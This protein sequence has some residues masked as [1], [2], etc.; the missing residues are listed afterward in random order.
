MGA[1]LL[2]QML[3][4]HSVPVTVHSV[5]SGTVGAENLQSGQVSWGFNEDRITRVEQHLA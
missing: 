2:L 5:N 3:R 4:K 1:E